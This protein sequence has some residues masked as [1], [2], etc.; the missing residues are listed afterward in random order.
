MVGQLH[1]PEV[2][3]LYQDKRIEIHNPGPRTLYLWGGAYGDSKVSLDS[4]PPRVIVPG[5][6][7]YL[8][9]D[10]FE[11]QLRTG[12]ARKHMREATTPFHAFV[13]TEDSKKYTIR[14]ILLGKIAD[15]I[16]SVH[17]QILPTLEGWNDNPQ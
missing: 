2:L 9:V 15:G 8:F 7:Y 14:G 10:S 16:L 5:A 13:T 4:S 17:T 6:Y 12:L 3:L 11:R 1:P